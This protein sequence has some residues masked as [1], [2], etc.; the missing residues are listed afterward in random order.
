MKKLF[1]AFPLNKKK[2]SVESD[3]VIVH[4]SRSYNDLSDKPSLDGVTIQG[5]MHE[6]DP[7]VGAWAKEQTRPVYNAKDV[8]AIAEGDVSD[9]GVTEISKL[10]E[11]L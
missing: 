6:T 3:G 8:G 10:W 2:M 1:L 4:E 9:I 11:D 5:E 7:T